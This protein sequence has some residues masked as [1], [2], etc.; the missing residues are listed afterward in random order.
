MTKINESRKCKVFKALS[1]ALVFVWMVLIFCLSAQE[2][3]DSAEL[4]N[5]FLAFIN[6]FLGIDL[7]HF[8]V[9][10]LAHATEY[11]FLA[12]FFSN[13]FYF[14]KDKALPLLSLTLTLL[15]AASDE[16]HQYFIPGRACSFKDILVDGT[17]AIIGILVFY[18]LHKF[19]SHSSQRIK[20]KN[21][22]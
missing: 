14:T 10:K 3:D 9:H 17:G 7:S 5:A 13:A 15:Y 19:L 22:K 12:V 20:I 6:N 8:F 4:S 16:I 2:S 11:F 21:N 18:L 1:W